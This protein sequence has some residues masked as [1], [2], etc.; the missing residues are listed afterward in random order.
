[1]CAKLLQL[2]PTLCNSLDSSPPGSS[3]HGILQGSVWGHNEL[4][5]KNVDS[6]CG[7]RVAAG[8]FSA[9]RGA[10]EKCI[11]LVAA[12]GTRFLHI[13][14]RHTYM[15]ACVH[16]VFQTQMAAN[17]SYCYCSVFHFLMLKISTLSSTFI[18]KKYLF[19]ACWVFTAARSFL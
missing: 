2:Y 17:Y 10:C 5:L 3:V 1:M 15:C 16:D 14:L 19:L 6:H 12:T 18:F 8:Y 4:G 11:Y 9:A 13:P 7:W